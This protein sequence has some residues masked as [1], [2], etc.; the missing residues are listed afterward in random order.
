MGASLFLAAVLL[1]GDSTCAS[2]TAGDILLLGG[3]VIS[4]QRLLATYPTLGPK[5]FRSVVRNYN[6]SKSPGAHAQG[7]LW[8]TCFG[9]GVT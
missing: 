7:C 2:A 8:Q 5:L 4:P 3:N 6:C 1:L 9:R